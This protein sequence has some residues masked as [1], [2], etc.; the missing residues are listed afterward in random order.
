MLAV[1]S[2]AAVFKKHGMARVLCGVDSEGVKHDEPCFAQDM[3]ELD[4]GV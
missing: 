2:R 3:R 1:N 4:E